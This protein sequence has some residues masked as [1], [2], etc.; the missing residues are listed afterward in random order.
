MGVVAG[1][2]DEV[3]IEE[4]EPE[5]SGEGSEEADSG[6]VVLATCFLH[7]LREKARHRA[8]PHFILSTIATS[9]EPRMSRFMDRSRRTNPRSYDWER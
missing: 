8:P 5:E 4:E 9:I 6:V 1:E 7:L 3:E 2:D